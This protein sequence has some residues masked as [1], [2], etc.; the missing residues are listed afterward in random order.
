[1]TSVDHWND[2]NREQ[3]AAPGEV[4]RWRAFWLLAAA[5]LMT[6]VDLAIVN[7]ALPTIGREL[8]F[9]Q[10]DLQWVVTALTFGGFLL[11]GGRAADLLGRR[12][13]FMAG[14][15][16]VAVASTVA[17]TH[18]RLLLDQGHTPAAA[19]TGGFRWAFWVSGLTALAAVPVAFLLIRRTELARAVAALQQKAPA[20]RT[21]RLM[22]CAFD[23]G[24]RKSPDHSPPPRVPD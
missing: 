13:L 17:A 12:R 11:L 22:P 5:F 15:A 8:H 14:L 21:H 4:R 16:D 24:R 6:V 18:S 9:P 23:E 2:V 19:L 10:T 20:P 1:M 7:V 3:A